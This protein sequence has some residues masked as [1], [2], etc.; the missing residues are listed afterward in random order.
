MDNRA[1]GG[2]LGPVREAGGRQ[3]LLAG[4]GLR[5]L[6][7]DRMEPDRRGRVRRCRGRGGARRERRQGRRGR[8]PG[9]DVPGLPDR[10]PRLDDP[11]A[12]VPVGGSIRRSASRTSA[13]RS[14]SPASTARAA[15]RTRSPRWSGSAATT[16][17]GALTINRLR[18][19]GTAYPPEIRKQY[20]DGARGCDPAGRRRGEAPR[21]HPCRGRGP[22]QPVRRREHDGRL[23]A[24]VRQLQVRRRRPRPRLRGPVD[25][26]ML[27]PVPPRLLPVLRDDDGDPAPPA[28]HPDAPGC[29]VPARRTRCARLFER[30]SVSAAHAWVEVYFPGYGWVEFDPTGGGLAAAE[31]LPTGEPVADAAAR[32]EL[33]ARAW[34]HRWPRVLEDDTGPGTTGGGSVVNGPGDR[35]RAHRRRDP[36]A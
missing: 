9:G 30:V 24:V 8:S 25:R 15:I 31:P 17:D 19:A 1:V 13:T 14:S 10:L 26:R 20:L 16:Q 21:G 2:V 32:L 18:A 36:A 12:A 27:R 6:R 3:P 35:R 22:G 28:R 5:H 4:G 33:R 34:S 7:P 29:R 23:P 11:V